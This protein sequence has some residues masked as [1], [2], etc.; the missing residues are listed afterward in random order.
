MVLCLFYHQVIIYGISQGRGQLAVV[1]NSL[2][3]AEI[4]KD[5]SFPDSLKQKLA[6]ISEIKKYAYDSLGIKQ[7]DN[8]TYVY[9]QHNKSILI[10]ISACEPFSFQPKEYPSFLVIFNQILAFA[11]QLVKVNVWV[12]VQF[13]FKKFYFYH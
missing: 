6:L 1:M 13:I 4:M 9:N 3:V 7:S 12:Y 8:Y 11:Q 10:T 2:P 5:T